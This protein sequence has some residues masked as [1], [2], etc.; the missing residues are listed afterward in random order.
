[1]ALPGL[2]F[3][4]APP[5]SVPL[6]F[7]LVAPW[8]GVAAALMLALAGPDSLASRWDPSAV[9]A[10]H[11]LT[12]GVLAMCMIGALMQM[13]PVVAGAAL[14]R[15][16]RLA[17]LIQPPL[18]L[19]VLLL[20]WGFTAGRTEILLAA[21]APLALALFAFVGVALSAMA[22]AAAK[23][24]TITAMRLALAALALTVS[25][26]LLAA[27]TYAGRTGLPLP[28]LADIHL[29]WGLLGWIGILVVGVAYQV[30]PMFQMTPPYP[31]ALTRSLGWLMAGGPAAFSL[32]RSFELE[33]LTRGTTMILFAGFALF[34]A[35]TLRLQRQRRRPLP[36][37][38]LRFWR[39]AMVSLLASGAVWLLGL[40][41]PPIAAS[42]RQPLVLGI[43]WL[44]GFAWSAVNGMLY[45]I[46]PFLVWLHLQS[47][48]PPRG[49]TPNMKQVIAETATRRQAL[50]HET[51]L[52]LLLAA[53]FLRQFFY[54]ALLVGALSFAQVGA[55]LLSAWRCYRL[56]VRRLSQGVPASSP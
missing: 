10:T 36:D 24:A 32:G 5:I 31:L 37:I 53:C 48:R 4:Q 29:G 2:L 54:P 46:V 28:T 18:M 20:A 43:L 27:W 15:P 12:L 8:F 1:M 41:A 45:K 7:F 17:W 9:A 47:Q 16:N 30:V 33:W 35:T 21:L 50:T 11:L 14:T 56:H 34:A 22:S 38:T 42:P 26:G 40:I 51:A 3:E 44:M 55:N 6:R 23:N 13:L 19:G 49:T 39:V 25:L 52:I